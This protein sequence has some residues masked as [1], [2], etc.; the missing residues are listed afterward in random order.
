VSDSEIRIDDQLWELSIEQAQE[1]LQEFLTTGRAT[2]P[3][4]RI[5]V[6]ELNYS[7]DSVIRAAHQI[8]LDIKAGR[9]DEEQKSLWFARLGFYFGEALCR[10]KTGLSWG[11][12]DSEYAFANHPVVIGFADGEEAPTITICRNMIEAVVEGLSP[13][14]RI[15]KGVMNWFGKPVAV[16]S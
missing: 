9:L 10:A 15:D 12:G 4:L 7:Q 13:P 16:S 8:V 14:G 6:I 11:L 1:V 3:S 5:D 2:L